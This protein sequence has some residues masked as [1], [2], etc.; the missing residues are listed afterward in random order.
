MIY[1]ISF[2]FIFPSFRCASRS[3]FAYW[4]LFSARYRD[5]VMSFSLIKRRRAWSM[6]RGIALNNSFMF[7]RWFNMLEI[8]NSSIFRTYGFF[9]VSDENEII[10]WYAVFNKLSVRLLQFVLWMWYSLYNCFKIS[11]ICLLSLSLKT[12]MLLPGWLKV[13]IQKYIFL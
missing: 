5:G 11:K 10:Y 2:I 7:N 3:S 1:A 4:I 12:G 13:S 8:R 6:G 9:E